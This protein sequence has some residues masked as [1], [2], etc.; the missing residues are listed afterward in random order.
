MRKYYAHIKSYLYQN[1]DFHPSIKM[2]TREEVSSQ[3]RSLNHR[4]ADLTKS[5]QW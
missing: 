2:D 5:T 1:C 3:Y 4:F